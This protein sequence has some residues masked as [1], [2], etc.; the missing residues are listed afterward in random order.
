MKRK[1][2]KY[3]ESGVQKDYLLEVNVQGVSIYSYL[4]EVVGEHT[5]WEV[6]H[7]NGH[8]HWYCHASGKAKTLDAAKA[9]AEAAMER[10]VDKAIKGLQKWRAK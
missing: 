6:N 1:W 5:R 3:H 4:C 9:K 2:V 10:L 8:S 7:G